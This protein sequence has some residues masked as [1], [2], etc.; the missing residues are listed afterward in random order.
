MAANIRGNWRGRN[1]HALILD[2][3]SPEFIA[4][5]IAE[6]EVG[7]KLGNRRRDPEISKNNLKAL[8]NGSLDFEVTYV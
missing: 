1:W 8:R 5:C 3:G 2:Q 6:F 4:E 7:V